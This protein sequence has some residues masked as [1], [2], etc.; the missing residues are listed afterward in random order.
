MHKKENLFS[1]RIQAA[2]I[3]TCKEIL[4]LSEKVSQVNL[5]LI[6]ILFFHSLVEKYYMHTSWKQ[7][8]LAW[9]NH[10]GLHS[11]VHPFS[12]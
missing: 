4:F 6:F 2:E 1:H 3:K 10:T 11:D 7:N 5:S 8:A 9:R 12:L